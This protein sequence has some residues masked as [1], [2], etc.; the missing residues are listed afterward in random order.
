MDQ[1]SEHNI[2]TKLEKDSAVNFL[3][4]QPF[5][6]KELNDFCSQI[7]ISERKERTVLLEKVFDI[8]V[9]SLPQEKLQ[10][11]QIDLSFY[12][13][14]VKAAQTTIVEFVW[15]FSFLQ[16]FPDFLHVSIKHCST[17]LILII[18]Y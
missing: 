6:W 17:K 8:Y 10:D 13:S 12:Q 11:L 5:L 4:L 15:I 7:L 16:Q 1:K 18:L 9:S 14:P 2:I 3:K